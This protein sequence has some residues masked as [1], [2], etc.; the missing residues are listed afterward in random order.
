MKEYLELQLKKKA[1]EIVMLAFR[2]SSRA[3]GNK[4]AALSLRK[5]AG[6]IPISVFEG[7]SRTFPEDKIKYFTEARNAAFEA[8]YYLD[9]LYSSKNISYYSYKMI[10]S[11]IDLLDKLIVSRLSAVDKRGSHKLSALNIRGKLI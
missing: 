2:I 9:L 4:V 8:R 11:R 3:R 10:T 1:H 7:Q 6:K 5:S